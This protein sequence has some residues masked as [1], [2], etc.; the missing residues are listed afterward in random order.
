MATNN[1]RHGC[2]RKRSQIKTK[3]MGQNH[4][5]KPVERLARVA[6]QRAK[7]PAPLSK[8]FALV[9]SCSQSSHCAALASA[10]SPSSC[11][12]R[13]RCR[14]L[15]PNDHWSDTRRGFSGLTGT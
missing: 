9:L 14:A 13:E 10:S 7:R 3:T 12:S 11:A 15:M 2:E 6:L 5:T 8:G 1:P 4:W